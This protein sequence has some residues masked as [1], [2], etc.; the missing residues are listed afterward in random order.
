MENITV[1]TIENFKKAVLESTKPVIIDA[2]AVWCGPCIYMAPTFEALAKEYSEKYSFAKLNVDEQRELAIQHGITSV[3]TFLF[4]K[5]GKLV[6]QAIGYMSKE[7]LIQ[8][9]NDTFGK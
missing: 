9:L 8:K 7:D 4:F 6:S 1:L 5:E 3:P 2:F